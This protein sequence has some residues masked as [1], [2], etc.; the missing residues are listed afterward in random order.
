MKIIQKIWLWIK[1]LWGKMFKKKA[2][3]AQPDQKS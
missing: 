2:A 3:P 1:G